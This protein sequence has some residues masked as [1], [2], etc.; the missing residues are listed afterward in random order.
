MTAAAARIRDTQ[1][2]DGAYPWI[3]GQPGKYQNVQGVTALGV[4]DAYELTADA[5]LLESASK[6][7]DWLAA[8]MAANPG[9]YI[10]ASNAYF[11]AEF[12][13]VT[14]EPADLDLARAAYATAIA[15]YGSPAGIVTGIIQARANQGHTNLGLWDAGLFLRAAQDI[16]AAADADAMATAMRTQTIVDPMNSAANWYEL[17]LAGALFGYGEAGA[18]D[19]VEGMLAI[20]DAL[21][22]T[23]CDNGS[24]PSTWQGVVYCDEVQ[25]TA[26][27]VEGLTYVGSL[28][29][30]QAGC[31]YIASSQ[32]ETGGWDLGGYEISEINAEAASALAQCLLP[33]RNGAT[34]Y[35]DEARQLL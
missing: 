25:A 15:R 9:K 3:V 35:A 10:S 24:F 32:A 13:L 11:L 7:R 20:R 31:D 27:A 16:G 33:A 34:S 23:Q 19:D 17:G 6:N 30:A 2:A 8:Y 21:L 26:Y 4:L 5:T 29:E 12:A 18:L 22:A 14:A 1:F 28:L